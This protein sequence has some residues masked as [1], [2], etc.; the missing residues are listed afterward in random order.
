MKTTTTDAAAATLAPL[1]SLLNLEAV[2]GRFPDPQALQRA[3]KKQVRASPADA[4]A[5]RAAASALAT[6]ESRSEYLR[7]QSD[8]AQPLALGHAPTPRG[9]VQHSCGN[10]TSS[11]AGR[12]AHGSASLQG[13]R[14][15]MEDELLLAVPIGGRAHAYGVFDGHGGARAARMLPRHL[16]GALRK[17]L[18]AAGAFSIEQLAA[19]AFEEIDA[20][21]CDRASADGWDDGSTALVAIIEHES[22]TS[23]CTL[24]LLQVGDCDAVLASALD[25]GIAD[26][27]YPLVTRHRPTEAAEAQRL[28]AVGVVASATGRVSGL[29]VSRAF[30]DVS[31]KQG[32]A[33]YL[34]ATPEV[35]T[36]TLSVAEAA[37]T[38]LILACDGLWDFVSPAEACAILLRRPPAGAQ[39]T[40]DELRSAA[41]RLADAALDRGGDDNVSVLVVPLGLAPSIPEVT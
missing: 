14:P 38:I 11:E 3:Y 10:G 40:A 25:G 33:P 29:A 21:I 13:R 17:R 28:A 12:C 4:S 35:A 24:T 41:L 27:G 36:R 16:P 9:K 34:I 5:L 26:G 23:G 37:N 18:A 22:P 19:A 2:D 8:V 31:Y 6:P 39:W 32:D 15:T 30:G 20:A 1:L 7:A